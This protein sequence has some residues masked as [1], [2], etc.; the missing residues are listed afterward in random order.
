MKKS[1]TKKSN[2][3]KSGTKKVI[4]KVSE[5]AKPSEKQFIQVGIKGTG[6]TFNA[7]QAQ[8]FGVKFPQELKHIYQFQRQC[9]QVPD[10]PTREVSLSVKNFNA[11]T[12]H[13]NNCFR[14]NVASE[15]RLFDTGIGKNIQDRITVNDKNNRLIID[16]NINVNKAS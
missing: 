16:I 13:T 9:D 5:K 7:N 6:K 10:A 15:Y 1:K 3:K 11:I 4:K 14:E 8:Q 12:P 2:V